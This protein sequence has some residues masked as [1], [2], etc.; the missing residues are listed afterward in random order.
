MNQVQKHIDKSETYIRQNE[1][2]NPFGQNVSASL[3]YKKIER[4][5][6]ATTYLLN[7]LQEGDVLRNEV[8]ATVVKLIHHAIVLKDGF[9]ASGFDKAADVL[10]SLRV[11]MTYI[12]MLRATGAVSDANLELYKSA[13][14]RVVAL[15]RSGQES[16]LSEGFVL[17]DDLIG[18]GHESV[19]EDIVKQEQVPRVHKEQK[20]VAP[21]PAK[22][23]RPVA[24]TPKVTY[25]P[26][27]NTDRRTALL[28]VIESR[29]AVTIR[30]LVSVVP[31]IS[32]K[33]IQ[34]E[35]Q[36]MIIDGILKK[37]GDRR[38]TTYSRV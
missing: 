2:A 34:R 18:K 28:T 6:V 19:R 38:W 15:I 33:T 27:G 36:A 10:V 21:T 11:L 26:K 1:V 31:G 20:S 37:E 32:E 35:L 25:V 5:A 17:S 8:H 3:L 24:H 9:R 13:C 16:H 4:I 23:I 30:D 22:Q 29:G 12:D 14:A 7:Q